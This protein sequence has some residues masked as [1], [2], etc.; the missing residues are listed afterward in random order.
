[1]VF[2]FFPVF[3]MMKKTL[4]AGVACLTLLSAFPL[5]AKSSDD[6]ENNG[7]RLGAHTNVSID[8]ACMQSAVR[9]RD[10]A[11]VDAFG[12]Y[13]QSLASALH[14]RTDAQVSAWAKV[15]LAERAIALKASEKVFTSSYNDASRQLDKTKKTIRTTYSNAEKNC[16][17][18]G[19][20]GSSSSVSSSST[21]TTSSTSSVA[22]KDV[23]G[24]LTG[25][26]TLVAGLPD[27][28]RTYNLT[29]TG[30][31]SVV[32]SVAA[33]GSVRTL[34]FIASGHA[35]GDITLTQGSS[36]VVLHLEGPVQTGFSGLPTSFHY[37]VQ[38]ANGVFANWTNTSG[39]LELRLKGDAN[40]SL[41]IEFNG[42]CNR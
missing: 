17:K 25:A 4:V 14:T 37:T 33:T 28:G 36:S 11:L 2:I 23:N 29:G 27:V 1:M 6:H 3:H 41:K 13:N 19:R 21:S 30:S 12:A 18:G 24:K 9:A 35:T 40:G 10:N 15:D 7:L 31:V 39:N 5:L 20:T 8:T 22:C 38:S 16:K 34:G 32:G 42:R 26:F